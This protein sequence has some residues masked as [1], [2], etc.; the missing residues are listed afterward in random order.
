MVAYKLYTKDKEIVM[1]VSGEF[2]AFTKYPENEDMKKLHLAAGMERLKVCF[3]CGASPVA[4]VRAFEPF[5]PTAYCLAGAPEGKTTRHV[6]A[7]ACEGTDDYTIEP[8]IKEKYDHYVPT[9][10]PPVLGEEVLDPRIVFFSADG[11]PI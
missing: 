6:Y 3:M 5:D 9:E 8:A 4:D 10:T 7:L 1:N 2:R 11:K